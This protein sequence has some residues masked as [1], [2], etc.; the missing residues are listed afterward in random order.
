MP[1]YM[2][3]YRTKIDGSEV[4]H[5]RYIEAPDFKTG[6]RWAHLQALAMSTYAMGHEKITTC[7]GFTT[8]ARMPKEAAAAQKKY[9]FIVMEDP[10]TKEFMKL[11]KKDF[12]NWEKEYPGWLATEVMDS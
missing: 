9:G 7:I 8:F 1:Y 11:I 3:M 10:F 5:T 2:A 12:K 6:E 4:E